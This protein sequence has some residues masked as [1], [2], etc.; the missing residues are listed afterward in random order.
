MNVDSLVIDV[1]WVSY[2]LDNEFWE[3]SRRS[4]CNHEEHYTCFWLSIYVVV[5]VA[6]VVY[7]Y[8]TVNVALMWCFSYNVADNVVIAPLSLSLSPFVGFFKFHLWSWFLGMI[9]L[10][11]LISINKI[12]VAQLSFSFVKPEAL[13]L[14][15]TCPLILANWLGN[16]WSGRVPAP[17]CPPQLVFVWEGFAWVSWLIIVLNNYRLHLTKAFYQNP[18][19]MCR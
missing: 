6:V 7:P 14:F 11:V 13:S 8:Q 1:Y 12:Q 9:N 16:T 4:E 5:V 17:E 2:R 18:T 3:R 15:C 19:C 10:L